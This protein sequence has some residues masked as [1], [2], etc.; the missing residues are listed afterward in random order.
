MADFKPDENRTSINNRCCCCFF[1][2]CFFLWFGDTWIDQIKGI[3]FFNFG[4]G[5]YFP[6]DW[7]GNNRWGSYGV[8]YGRSSQVPP[9]SQ[10]LRIVLLQMAQTEQLL[11][12]VIHVII[13]TGKQVE[14]VC[15]FRFGEHTLQIPS[16]KSIV[17]FDEIIFPQRWVWHGC[18]RNHHD[19]F[20]SLLS[21]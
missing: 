5:R 21:S 4:L 3:T 2:F 14:Q 18:I 8:L 7:F 6:R 12:D 1:L 17:L 10:R 16:Y 11:G 9:R 15:L 13:R 19:H 20:L